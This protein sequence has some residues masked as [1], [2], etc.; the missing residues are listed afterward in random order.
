MMSAPSSSLCPLLSS[1]SSVALAAPPLQHAVLGPSAQRHDALLDR[2]SPS[3]SHL[4]WFQRCVQCFQR[5]WCHLLDPELC[6]PSRHLLLQR[7]Q[8]PDERQVSPWEAWLV[9]KCCFHWLV[10][11]C[12]PSFLHAKCTADQPKLNELRMCRLR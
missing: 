4:P 8:S 7:P 11:I 6:Y 5:L 9:C 1:V 3:R 12:H 2:P 10:R